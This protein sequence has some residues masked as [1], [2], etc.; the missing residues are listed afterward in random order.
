MK[1]QRSNVSQLHRDV[2]NLVKECYPN[3]KIREEEPINVG[4][5]TLYLDIF[6][7][8]L[9]IAVECDGEQH[10][11]FNKFYH[12]NSAAFVQQKKNDELKNGYC[13]DNNISLARVKFDDKLTKDLMMD[14][15]Y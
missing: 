9:K 13:E 10:F 12:T 2:Y 6:I 14:K 11:K 3:E 1:K 4:G 15:T 7:P 8:R 5:K